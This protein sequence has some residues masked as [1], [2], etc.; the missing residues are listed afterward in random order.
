[1]KM[2]TVVEAEQL[3]VYESAL[4]A[5][6]AIEYGKHRTK[7]PGLLHCRSLG[8]TPEKALQSLAYSGPV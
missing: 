6:R 1:M 2:D 5:M 8:R 4:Y 7:W 3:E